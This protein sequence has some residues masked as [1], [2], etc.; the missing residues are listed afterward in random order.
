MAQRLDISP[1]VNSANKQ[2]RFPLGELPCRR[3]PVLG[4]GTSGTNSQNLHSPVCKVTTVPLMGLLQK[5]NEAW[6]PACYRA[7]VGL[8]VT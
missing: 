5:L 7:H 4:Q 8:T 6:H 2:Q 3:S 1:T